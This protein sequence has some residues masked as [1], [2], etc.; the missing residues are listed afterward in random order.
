MGPFGNELGYLSRCEASW[1]RATDPSWLSDAKGD[2]YVG[3]IVDPRRRGSAWLANQR[4]RRLLP[5]ERKV[6]DCLSPL[7]STARPVWC[8]RCQSYHTQPITSVG[9][10]LP[11]WHI[12]RTPEATHY[13]WEVVLVRREATGVVERRRVGHLLALLCPLPTG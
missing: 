5:S 3:C 1:V 2:A 7:G 10:S 4:A 13:A 6:S 8:W 12:L 11:S 9:Q